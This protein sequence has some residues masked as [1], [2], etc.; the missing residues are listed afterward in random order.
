MACSRR[1]FSC[2]PNDKFRMSGGLSSSLRFRDESLYEVSSEEAEGVADKD[3]TSDS[4]S[5][6]SDSTIGRSGA[7]Y[8]CCLSKCWRFARAAAENCDSCGSEL[9]EQG[10]AAEKEPS[11]RWVGTAE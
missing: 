8:E 10:P 4:S 9:P 6:G 5:L 11:W 1:S 7:M 3:G 2:E